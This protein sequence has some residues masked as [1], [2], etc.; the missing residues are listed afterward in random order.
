VAL[1]VHLGSPEGETMSELWDEIDNELLDCLA[2]RGSM[3]PAEI[4]RRLAISE[5]AVV[6]LL[7]MLAREGRVR[8]RVVESVE[9]RALAS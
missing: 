5:E 7:A 2:A 6:S 1:A 9:P 8:I 4:G 3:A